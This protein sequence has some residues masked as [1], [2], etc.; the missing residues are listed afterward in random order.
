MNLW[1]EQ[2]DPIER[3]FDDADRAARPT[4]VQ[5]T[6]RRQPCVLHSEPGPEFYWDEDGAEVLVTDELSEQWDREAGDVLVI[7]RTIVGTCQT[8]GCTPAPEP[9]PD[10][11]PLRTDSHTE[12]P[13]EPKTGTGPAAPVFWIL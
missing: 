5:R 6:Y 1:T 13:P 8:A 7:R 2:D 10:P 11:E 4:R 9:E 12:E 3:V